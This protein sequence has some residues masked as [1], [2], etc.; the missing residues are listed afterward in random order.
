MQVGRWVRSTKT[1]F[2][3]VSRDESVTSLAAAERGLAVTQLGRR[4]HGSGGALS[5][6][7]MGLK[8]DSHLYRI[9]PRINHRLA[10]PVARFPRTGSRTSDHA[11]FGNCTTEGPEQGPEVGPSSKRIQKSESDK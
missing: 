8:G 6:L 3:H 7:I 11:V 2:G 5:S 9:W 10:Q 4:A 1:H